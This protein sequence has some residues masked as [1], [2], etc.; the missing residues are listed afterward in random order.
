MIVDSVSRKLYT[1]VRTIFV[2][3]NRWFIV[4]KD[5]VHHETA[6]SYIL[7]SY[8]LNL[9]KLIISKNLLTINEYS[10][11]GSY[12]YTTDL[13]SVPYALIQI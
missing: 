5:R 9:N 12:K 6:A 2:E 13:V 4:S 8:S 10:L 7:F 11:F 3:K 1:R